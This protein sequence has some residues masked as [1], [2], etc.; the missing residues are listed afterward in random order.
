MME[1]AMI[2]TR[3]MHSLTDFLR[4]HKAHVARL[5]ETRMP[6]V[7]TVNGRTEVLIQDVE[8]Y[9]DLLDRLHH[10]VVG[11]TVRRVLCHRRHSGSIQGEIT[12]RSML[13]LSLTLDHWVIDGAPAA[14]FLHT[15]TGHLADP[16]WM[17]AAVPPPHYPALS[18]DSRA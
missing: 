9:Q 12:Q 3:Q 14:A 6:E 13:F 11:Q 18:A 5:K 17:V 1:T 10:S 2:D 16:W 7:L 8:S 4:N 15:V